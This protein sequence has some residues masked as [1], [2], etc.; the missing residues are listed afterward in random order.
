MAQGQKRSEES[1]AATA[2]AAANAVTGGPP[3]RQLN[4]QRGMPGPQ[5]HRSNSSIG[6]ADSMM[7]LA[8]DPPINAALR[9]LQP[10]DRAPG[11]GL[12]QLNPPALGGAPP[13]LPALEHTP[14]FVGHTIPRRT[15]SNCRSQS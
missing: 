6:S 14:H 7:S 3:P 13:P 11:A 5:T 2:L 10:A 1:A 15:V 12:S 8:M 9:N 4:F